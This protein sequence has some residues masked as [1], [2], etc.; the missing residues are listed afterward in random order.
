MKLSEKINNKTIIYPLRAKSKEDALH[1]L[2]D[3]FQSLDYLT[4]TTKLFS[5]LSSK[6]KI[7]NSASGRGVAYHYHTSVEVTE[8]LAVL[9]ISK[10]GIDYNATDGLFCHFIL[11]IL[12]PMS[13][14]NSHR[15][16]INLFQ[17][18]IKNPIVKSNLL[19]LNSS[20]EVEKIII[21]WE[22]SDTTFDIL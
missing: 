20:E 2:L 11:L 16:L 18:L 6:D 7:F 15:K 5:Y 19:E 8:T 21:N 3:Y 10:D 13:S 14:P 22:N 9:G 1:E 4:A 12:E 17:E